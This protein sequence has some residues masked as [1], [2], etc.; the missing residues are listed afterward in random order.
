MSS[1]TRRLS[2]TFGAD[3]TAGLVAKPKAVCRAA[4]GRRE[5]DDDRSDR[6]AF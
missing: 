1:D 4:I 6:A 3:P 5:P 2:S